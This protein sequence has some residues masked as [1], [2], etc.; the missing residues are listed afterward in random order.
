MSLD[1]ME[2]E[3][4]PLDEIEQ[5]QSEF[6]LDKKQAQAIGWIKKNVPISGFLSLITD[7]LWVRE[8]MKDIEEGR[9]QQRTAALKMLGEWLGTLGKNTKAQGRPATVKIEEL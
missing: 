8:I 1:D 4:I 3:G 6:K 2:F 7:E 5:L 9:P